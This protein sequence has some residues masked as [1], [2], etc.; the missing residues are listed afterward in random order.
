MHGPIEVRRVIQRFN[1]ET[2]FTTEIT[3]A[4]VSCTR[5]MSTAATLGEMSFIQGAAYFRASMKAVRD[6]GAMVVG[7][8]AIRKGVG[9][10]RAANAAAAARAAP[11]AA[12]AQAA[13]AEFAGIADMIAREEAARIFDPLMYKNF[14]SKVDA[15]KHSLMKD[16]T[17]AKAAGGRIVGIGAATKG[18]T[19]LNYC[20]IDSTLLEFVTDAS[21]LKIGKYTPGSNIPIR[22]DEAIHPEITHALILPWNLSG[23]LRGKL[24][25]KFPN[26]VFIT[27]HME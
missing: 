27:P 8:I 7:D 19:L 1:R 2:G 25:P 15:F 21:P 4:L 6:V 13:S 9:T 23:F 5:D 12:A 26:L 22:P 16:L 10:F 11:T 24:A 14:M 3:P 17:E 18:N 20:G